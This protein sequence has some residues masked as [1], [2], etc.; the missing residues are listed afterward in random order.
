MTKEKNCLFLTI[1][2]KHAISYKTSL[3]TCNLVAAHPLR[4]TDLDDMIY[5]T[6]NTAFTLN[7][8]V[9]EPESSTPLMPKHC[10]ALDTILSRFHS[11][12]IRI[13]L[14][15]SPHLPVF[16]DILRVSFPR[17]FQLR[18]CMHFLFPHPSH[19]IA[20]LKLLGLTALTIVSYAVSQI[21]HVL[22][23]YIQLFSWAL[24]FQIFV[25]WILPSK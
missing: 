22:Q 4:N 2:W 11:S 14:F 9:V 6:I 16:L 12:S 10:P 19:S 1:T 24:S 21:A 17:A 5:T 8:L 25:I 20:H 23:P 3:H 18:F 15:S 13:S 7:F